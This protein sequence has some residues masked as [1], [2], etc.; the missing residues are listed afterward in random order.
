MTLVIKP[1]SL[2]DSPLWDA[3]CHVAVNATLLHSRRFLSYH[4]DRF[5]DLSL[6]LYD[7]DQL[8]A[9]LP[10]ARAPNDAT[11]VVSHPGATYGGFVHAGQLAGE[12]AIDAFHAVAAHYRSVGCDRLLYKPVPH[13]YAQ[14]PAADDLYA[15]FRLGAERQRC[16]LSSTID[17]SFRRPVSSRRKRSLEKARRVV[18]VSADIAKLD[19][20][21]DVV[22]DNLARKHK[23]RPVHSRTEIKDLATRFP[24]EIK[25]RTA[26]IGDK[27]VA[28]TLLFASRQVWHAQYIASSEDG[29]AV[30]ALDAVFDTSIKDAKSAGVRYFDFG[31][32]NEDHGRVL[33]AG[34]YRFKTEFG[35]GGVAHEFYMVQL[36]SL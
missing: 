15:L 18:S 32:S 6:L 3:F 30:S 33:N 4:G 26:H 24:D 23:T 36:D 2:D 1:F 31:S 27:I 13:I 35:G 16:D 21:W 22:E 29:Y 17:L 25:L 7:K 28:G 14:S 8:R 19:A 20:L 5:E 10:A 12:N 34:L 9:I 11:L